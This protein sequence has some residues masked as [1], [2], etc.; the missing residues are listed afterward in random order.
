MYLKSTKSRNFQWPNQMIDLLYINAFWSLFD[1]KRKMSKKLRFAI[2]FN[3]KKFGQL[4]TVSS[5][6]FV[7]F[8]FEIS[9]S[10][11]SFWTKR[12]VIRM[13]SSLSFFSLFH[14]RK[15]QWCWNRLVLC[16]KLLLLFSLFCSCCLCLCVYASSLKLIRT[17]DKLLKLYY[18]FS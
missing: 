18:T 14:V 5:V 10:R 13:K 4:C 11:E 2:E 3:Y 12:T 15:K 6:L 7:G 1:Q 17:V 16:R 8:W 9:F